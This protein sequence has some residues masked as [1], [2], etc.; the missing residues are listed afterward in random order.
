LRQQACL[1]ETAPWLEGG[2]TESGEASVGE[3]F[4]GQA[5]GLSDVQVG[6]PQA[7]IQHHGAKT[8]K[9]ARPKCQLSIVI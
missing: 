1:D 2:E 5:L 8:Q 7:M 4:V 6:D 3:V 9:D